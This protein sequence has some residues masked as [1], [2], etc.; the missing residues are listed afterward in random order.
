MLERT[1]DRSFVPV[2]PDLLTAIG[3][4]SAWSDAV[5]VGPFVWAA[6][7]IGWDKKTGRL[8]D[9]IEAQ[10]EQALKNLKDVLER[11]GATLAD[12]VSI[13]AYLIDQDDYHRY[14][15]IYQRYFPVEPPARVSVVVA[16]NIHDALIDFE[17]VAV[18]R[19]LDAT[20]AGRA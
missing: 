17:V 4:E 16:Q 11:A 9:G 7:Q 19:G 8:L 5:C 6:G 3:A 18:K 14:E 12:V 20:G 13:R 10:A 1:S 15:P 2:D